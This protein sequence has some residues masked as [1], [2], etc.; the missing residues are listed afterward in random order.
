MHMWLQIP[1]CVY[2]LDILL[3]SENKIGFMCADKYNNQ[4]C[5][6]H[7]RTDRLND[8]LHFVWNPEDNGWWP[9]PIYQS[10]YR[11]QV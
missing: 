5:S 4:G 7:M 8:V 1:I 10:G 2:S 11:L 3:T 6:I 9:S